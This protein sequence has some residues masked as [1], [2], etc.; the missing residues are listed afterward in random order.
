MTFPSEIPTMIQKMAVSWMWPPSCLEAHHRFC[1]SSTNYS[2]MTRFDPEPRSSSICEQTFIKQ[3][4][5]EKPAYKR[6]ASLSASNTLLVQIRLAF[7]P[8]YSSVT[9]S[10]HSD[11]SIHFRVKERG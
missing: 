3:V 4:P 9:S 2:S 11:S 7:S 1:Y 10:T 8:V 6:L 5:I